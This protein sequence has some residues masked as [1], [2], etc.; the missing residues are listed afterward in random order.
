LS[1]ARGE[2]DRARGYLEELGNELPTGR[3]AV[4]AGDCY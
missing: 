4:K 1:S 3:P 2:R